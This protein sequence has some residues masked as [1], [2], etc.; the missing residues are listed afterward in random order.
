MEKRSEVAKCSS[1]HDR[2]LQLTDGQCEISN[3]DQ[4]SL[5]STGN[6]FDQQIK[7]NRFH[8]L[9][10]ATQNSMSRQTCRWIAVLSTALSKAVT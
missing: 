1:Q 5:P 8:R 10:F 7:C 2:D 3:K 4:K 6:I 9:G